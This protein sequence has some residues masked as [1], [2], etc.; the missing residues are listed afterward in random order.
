MVHTHDLVIVALYM[1]ICFPNT[2]IWLCGNAI[3]YLRQ[4]SNT[5]K[6]PTVS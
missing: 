5:C 4:M 1:H 3:K 2:L 6:T